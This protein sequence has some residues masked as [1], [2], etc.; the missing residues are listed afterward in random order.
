MTDEANTTQPARKLPLPD[1]GDFIFLFAMQIPLF[2]LPNLLFADGSTGWHLAAGDYILETGKIPYTD[3]FSNTF[4]DKAWVAYEWLFDMALA[5]LVKIGGTNLLAVVLA[6]LISFVFLAVYDRSRKEGASIAVASTLVTIAILNS[7]MHWLARPHI[8]TFW[9]VYIFSTTLE[10][11]YRGTISP[12]RMQ[13]TLALT[14]LLWV[15]CHPAF[16][17]G[18]VLIGIY[19]ACSVFLTIFGASQE[20]RPGAKSKVV[21]LLVAIGAVGSMTFLNPYGVELHKYILSYLQGHE[22][23]SVTDEYL[24]PKFK[25]NLHAACL[26]LLF[27]ALIIGLA[28]RKNLTLPQFTTTV[29]FFHLA[30]SAVR[31]MPLFS[32]VVT[33]T[34]AR[35]WSGEPPMTA[36]TAPAAPVSEPAATTSETAA[37]AAESAVPDVEPAAPSQPLRRIAKSLREFDEQELLCK[38]H[39]LPIGYSLFLIVIA[40][41]NGIFMDKPLLTSTFDP[42]TLPI[43]TTQYIKD[44]DLDTKYGFNYDNWGGYLRY[45]LGKRVFIDD[46]ADFYGSEFYMKY[47]IVLDLGDGWKKV[48]DDNGINW[49]LF[50]RYSRL[51]AALK[52]SGDWVSVASDDAS[53]LLVRK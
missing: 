4:P 35:L 51:V 44:H 53:E 42:T 24:S 8:V 13:I 37:P 7:C 6:S 11:F 18:F 19:L 9:S 16:L 34:I 38:M 36:T 26:E 50:P 17:V 3:L 43:K 29:G 12:R 30:L 22:V 1:V 52:A 21:P 20:Y 28:R 32:I 48:L 45:K 23:I 5:W 27:F 25:N 14:M 40:F 33:P 2:I 41:N 46:R 47:S 31:N 15:N 49:V 10:D 39:L